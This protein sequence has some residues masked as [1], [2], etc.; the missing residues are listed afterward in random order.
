[1]TKY[2]DTQCSAALPTIA[3]TAEG[4]SASSGYAT[5][6]FRSSGRPGSC[7]SSKIDRMISATVAGRRSRASADAARGSKAGSFWCRVRLLVRGS[8]R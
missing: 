8:P 2:M 7:T 1:M 6:W 3:T 4:D 5:A